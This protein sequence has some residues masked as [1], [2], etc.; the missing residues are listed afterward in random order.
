LN[1]KMVALL[2]FDCWSNEAK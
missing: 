2:I 1:T